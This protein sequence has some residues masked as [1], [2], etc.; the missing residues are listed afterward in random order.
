MIQQIKK[1]HKLIDILSVSMFIFCLTTLVLLYILNKFNMN[2]YT[3]IVITIILATIA[4]KLFT[5][6]LNIFLHY[7]FKFV[8]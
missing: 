4:S 6:K 8:K 5:K 1:N 7:L 2:E 3:L